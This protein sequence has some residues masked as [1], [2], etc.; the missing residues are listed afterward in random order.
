MLAKATLDLFF[1]ADSEKMAPK[2][3]FQALCTQI[4]CQRA[5]TMAQQPGAAA[6]PLAPCCQPGHWLRRRPTPWALVDSTDPIVGGVNSAQWALVTIRDIKL[7][8]R[9][10]HVF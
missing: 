4:G 5:D 6:A 1:H 9:P 10:C 2:A 7:E 3:P 8:A